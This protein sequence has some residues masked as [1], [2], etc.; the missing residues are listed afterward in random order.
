MDKKFRGTDFK[1]IPNIFIAEFVES[2]PG[3]VSTFICGRQVGNSLTDNSYIDDGYRYHD[4]L[5]FSH[6]AILGWSPVTRWLLGKRNNNKHE[7]S[8]EE[9][10]NA[11]VFALYTEGL[12]LSPL[13]IELIIHRVKKFG[14]E[15][16]TEGEWLKSINAGMFA[17][18]ILH[19]H[20]GGKVQVDLDNKTLKVYD[21]KRD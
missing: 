2:E 3:M 21:Q 9:G 13:N 20:K 10:I 12:Y 5:H 1:D 16:N 19:K 6:A 11:E 8:I 7:F 14:L 17:L 4:I 18:K 15:N